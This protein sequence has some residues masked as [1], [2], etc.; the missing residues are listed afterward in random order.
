MTSCVHYDKTFTNSSDLPPS[1]P[2]QV[3][4]FQQSSIATHLVDNCFTTPVRSLGKG[5][6]VQRTA[7]L[8]SE[9]FVSVLVC[10][11]SSSSHACIL[12]G[13]DHGDVATHTNWDCFGAR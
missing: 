5:L 7:S 4:S 6:A 12:I 9:M 8:V 10:S 11:V 13:Y 2:L 3:E 1:L